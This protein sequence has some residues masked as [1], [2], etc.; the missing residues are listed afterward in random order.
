MQS[1]D[2]HIAKGSSDVEQQHNN[3]NFRESKL[4]DFSKRQTESYIIVPNSIMK[5]SSNSR[6]CLCT[7]TIRMLMIN[8]NLNY[9]ITGII[10]RKFIGSQAQNFPFS[11]F[12][13]PMDFEDFQRR[14]DGRSTTAHQPS[15]VINHSRFYNKRFLLRVTG[16]LSVTFYEFIITFDKVFDFVIRISIRVQ[17]SVSRHKTRL[18]LTL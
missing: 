1:F 9:R 6:N 15:A 14:P 10:S 12:S 4:F 5:H 11:R 8:H 7:I 18:F 2:L 17:V 3:N 13:L 16:P